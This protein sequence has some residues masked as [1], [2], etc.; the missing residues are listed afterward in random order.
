MPYRG[1]WSYGDCKE[2]ELLL[3]TVKDIC[4]ATSFVEEE[5]F[6]LSEYET[7]MRCLLDE[8]ALILSHLRS[9]DQD[10]SALG[11]IMRQAWSDREK[12][13]SHTQKLYSEYDKLL[14]S[15]NNHR[16]R[17]QII[18][19]QNQY[20]ANETLWSYKNLTGITGNEIN[21]SGVDLCGSYLDQK[22]SISIS[23]RENQPKPNE[24]IQS[25]TKLLQKSE[26]KTNSKGSKE[27]QTSMWDSCNN[28]ETRI[29]SSETPVTAIFTS[30][31]TE[32]ATTRNDNQRCDADSFYNEERGK[33]ERGNL[34]LSNNE[35]F[36]VNF[37]SH[38]GVSDCNLDHI[39]SESPSTS[40]QNQMRSVS[41]D[42]SQSLLHPNESQ[43]IAQ[44]PPMK[45]CQACQQLIHRNAP[46]CPLCKTKS[47]SRHPK[48]PKSRPNTQVTDI[49]DSTS[50][51]LAS[52]AV[53]DRNE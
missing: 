52:D 44:C 50:I 53:R 24:M 39:S 31:T 38:A 17:L 11:T 48:K 20:K 5:T 46:I 19:L 2:S 4:K 13:V 21:V 26:T 1:L 36:Q 6:K 12:N 40:I 35:P 34:P 42:F 49:P 22:Q 43:L 37:R 14:S 41:V 10:I 9:I 23:E 16:K 27:V 8:R 29:L 32:A 47:R 30:F 25:K 45:T 18:P 28:H 3:R 7:E 15:V 51:F 33:C